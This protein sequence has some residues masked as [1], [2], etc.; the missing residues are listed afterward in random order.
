[1]KDKAL[2]KTYQEMNCTACGEF[3][4]DPCHIQT[5]AVSREDRPDNLIPMCRKHHV[6]QGQIGWRKFC[7]KFPGVLIAINFKGWVIEP[8]GKVRRR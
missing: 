3:G 2:R 6:E 5:Y 4:A 7:E 8:D 1:M